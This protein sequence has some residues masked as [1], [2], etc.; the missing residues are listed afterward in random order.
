[1]LIQIVASLRFLETYQSGLGT[2][3]T[4]PVLMENLA[5]QAIGIVALLL[6]GQLTLTVRE[7]PVPVQ[8]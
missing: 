8:M 7:I 1:M 4:A 3:P 2:N 6:I 5:K